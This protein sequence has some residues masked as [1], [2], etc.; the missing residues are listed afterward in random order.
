M[1]GAAADISGPAGFAQGFAYDP[2]GGEI[3]VYDE[4]AKNLLYFDAATLALKRTLPIADLS[5]GDPW[6]AFEPITGTVTIASE[7]DERTG[8]PLMVLD[9]ASGAAVDRRDEEAGNLLVHPR[10][11][12]LYM[13]YFRRSR[14]V[15]IFDLS[16]GR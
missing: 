5:P 6:L 14:S 12:L 11:P 10:K 1:V 13:S 8:T 3:Y 15:K 9:R 16:N 2:V 7:A 4:D